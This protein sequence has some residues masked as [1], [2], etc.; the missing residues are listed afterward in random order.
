MIFD[1]LVVGESPSAMIAA[2]LL[3]RKG[4]KVAWVVSLAHVSQSGEGIGSPRVPDI[5]WD[6]LP[7]DLVR[8]L[9]QRL[10]VPY[11]HLEKEGGAG[12][13]I[14][15]P[16]FRTASIDGVRE[17]RRELKRI[18]ALSGPELDKI[19]RLEVENHEDEFLNRYWRALFKGSSSIQKRSLSFFP[20]GEGIAP[21]HIDIEG[22]RLEPPLKR[23][24]ELTVFPQSYLGQWVFPRS[25]VKHF[26]GNFSRLN[27]FAQGR[28]VSPDKIFRRVFQMGGGEIFPGEEGVYLEPHREKGVSL[29]LNQEE[30]VNGTVC[31]V[32]VSPHEAPEMFE[33]LHLPHRWFGREEAPEGVRITN[34]TFSMDVMGVPGGMGENLIL[35]TGRATD[36]FVPEEL[37]LLSLERIE[38]TT[39]EGHYTAFYEGDFPDGDLQKWANR[40][41]RRLE[42]LFPFMTSYIILKNVSVPEG[43]PLSIGH[44]FYDTTRKRKLGIT[45][46]KEG[47]LGKNIRYIGR[48]QLDYLGL[49][50]EII[51][52]IKAYQWVLDRLAKI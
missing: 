29:W 8:N 11:K 32:A 13:Q 22:M 10:G 36:P 33:R 45:K 15:S 18:F 28:L 34:I 49:E 35:Y 47:F 7:R 46:L 3:T 37:S 30:V 43:H 25:L 44:Y 51:T 21:Q 12:I 50:G 26:I 40:Q 19:V 39:V 5:V 41:I 52:G 17:F 23:L 20:G 42:N 14:V 6:L 4:L 24:I 38:P 1:A 16:E 2:S 9:L 31:L 48:Q 27:V